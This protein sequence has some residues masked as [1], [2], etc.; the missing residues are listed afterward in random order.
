MAHIRSWI[1]GPKWER[2]STFLRTLA[3]DLDL[4]ITIEK[5]KGILFERIFYTVIGE[6]EDLEKFRGLLVEYWEVR[7]K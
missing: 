5:E 3:S 2:L 6:E 4:E 7:A 1:D